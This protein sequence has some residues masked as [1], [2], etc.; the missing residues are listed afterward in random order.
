MTA[1]YTGR[2]GRHLVSLMDDAEALNL[3]D[4]GSNQT[5]YQAANIMDK[6]KDAGVS[7]ANFP[8][9]PYLQ[10]IFP[11]ATYTT[12]GV[13]YR[14]TQ[15]VYGQLTRGA[16]AMSLYTLDN[17]PANSPAGQTNRFFHPQVET[18]LLTES[19]V[20]VSNYNALQLSL[21]H[22]LTKNF[23]YDF[24]YT[25]SHS[26]D[27]V[28]NPERGASAIDNRYA[29]NAE[30]VIISAFNPSLSYANSDF[31]VRHLITADWTLALPYGHGQRFGGNAGKLKNE[32]FGGWNVN[33]IAKWSSAL[34]WSAL[35]A[36]GASTDYEFRSND[37]QIAP[38]PDTGHHAYLTS[39]TG[40]ITPNAFQNGTAAYTSF[41]Q[42]YAG[43]AGE[44]NNLRADGYFSLDPAISKSFQTF[45]KQSFKLIVEV[46]NVTN[47]TRFGLPPTANTGRSGAPSFGNYSTLLNSPRQ[48][49]FSGR[50][51]F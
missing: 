31:D 37:V 15:A 34:P 28:S 27:M 41:R 13:T 9:I 30:S 46:F 18:T 39:S 23:I 24:N 21:R 1:T 25:L 10:D 38:V 7:V 8:T 36:A 43:E 29:S 3:Y 26:L 40:V 11:N 50:Y 12:G 42:A 51:Y 4:P 6:A 48:M 32:V 49:Q 19:S 2:L 47:A 35:G 45:E 44:R 16:D 20:G 22:T 5:W 14:G 17:N 33:G